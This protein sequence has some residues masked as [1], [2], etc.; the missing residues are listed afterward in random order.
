MARLNQLILFPKMPE[1][2]N[3]LKIIHNKFSWF[4]LVILIRTQDF[5]LC[6]FH[7]VLSFTN[8][9]INT[10]RQIIFL[11]FLR[12]I[13]STYLEP[14]SSY[15]LAYIQGTYLECNQYLV[16]CPWHTGHNNLYLRQLDVQPDEPNR[17]DELRDFL[18]DTY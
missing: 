9:L 18:H 6:Q 17:Q 4:N 5:T 14:N 11:N 3:L 12:I 16:N 7:F 2:E 15:V 13:F 1:K 10:S 8:I